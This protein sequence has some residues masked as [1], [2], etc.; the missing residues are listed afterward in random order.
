MCGIPPPR[1][2]RDWEGVRAAAVC[3]VPAGGRAV[4]D[5]VITTRGTLGNITPTPTRPH[6]GGGRPPTGRE[7]G[8]SGP[9]FA[10][11]IGAGEGRGRHRQAERRRGLEVDD[12]LECRRLL[13]R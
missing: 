8:G 1:W 2:G 13:H 3:T 11:L 7:S 6:Q 10:N 12:E 9:S 4:G 5:D